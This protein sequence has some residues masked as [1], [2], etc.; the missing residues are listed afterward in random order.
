MLYMGHLRTIKHKYPR[1]IA[2]KFSRYYLWQFR[3][4]SYC[5]YINI[6]TIKSRLSKFYIAVRR[7]GR[8]QK[9]FQ[10][11]PTKKKT[12]YS[13]IKPLPGRRATEKRPKN[14]K[15]TKNSTI[16]PLSTI[17]IPCM[18]IPGGGKGYG[19]L[20]PAFMSEI[21]ETVCIVNL[22]KLQIYCQKLANYSILTPDTLFEKMFSRFGKNNEAY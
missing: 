21:V 17:F 22:Q 14:S 11:E 13:T 5:S 15:K 12:K 6:Q 20:S 1:I 7:Q 2:V 16:K 3:D 9:N 10:G 19:P 18:K 4:C 8:R